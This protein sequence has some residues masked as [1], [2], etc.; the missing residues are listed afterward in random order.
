MTADDSKP[1]EEYDHEHAIK[2]DNTSRHVDAAFHVDA[3]ER[4]FSQGY[5]INSV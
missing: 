3:F 2:L 4:D 5:S 1:D